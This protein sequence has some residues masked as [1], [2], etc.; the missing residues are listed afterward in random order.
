MPA[1]GVSSVVFVI[2]KPTVV[3]LASDFSWAA[4]ISA[5]KHGAAMKFPE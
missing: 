1:A 4:S 3:P 2:L 5:G